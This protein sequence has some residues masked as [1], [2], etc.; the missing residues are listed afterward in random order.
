MILRCVAKEKIAA[1]PLLPHLI[2]VLSHIID[3][4]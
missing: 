2:A 1:Q 4:A 3:Q